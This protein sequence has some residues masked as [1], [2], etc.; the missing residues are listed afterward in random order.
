VNPLKRLVLAGADLRDQALD[1]VE[2]LVVSRLGG[3][4][5]ELPSM[6]GVPSLAEPFSESAHPLSAFLDVACA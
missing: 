5:E 3:S 1:F 4:R 2:F 6:G